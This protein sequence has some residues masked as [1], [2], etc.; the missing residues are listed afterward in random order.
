MAI[1]RPNAPI[2]LSRVWS[3]SYSESSAHKHYHTSIGFVFISLHHI[4]S[5]SLRAHF[6][7]PQKQHIARFR[8]TLLPPYILDAD[9][10]AAEAE[11]D[12]AEVLDYG[13]SQDIDVHRYHLFRD[14]NYLS[15]LLKDDREPVRL[16]HGGL[17]AVH[18]ELKHEQG[19]EQ[20]TRGCETLGRLLP[21]EQT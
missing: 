12:G 8:E 1:A 14:R 20:W 6:T 5:D 4:S 17:L 15:S 21:S 10:C 13:N 16:L 19:Q 7:L 3:S 9:V 18:V 2:F 11:F